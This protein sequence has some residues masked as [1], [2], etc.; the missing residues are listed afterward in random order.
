MIYP[1]GDR[2]LI[3]KAQAVRD[4]GRVARGDIERVV[5]DGNRVVIGIDEVGRGCLAGPVYAAA[6]A[7][8]YKKLSARTDAEKKLIR[9]SKT[10]SPSQRGRI[11]P[12]IREISRSFAVADASVC[13]IDSRG[14]LQATFLAMHRA[15]QGLQVVPEFLLIDGHMPLPD[16]AIPQ[17]PV[18]KGDGL[19][20]AIAAASI[21]AKEARDAYMRDISLSHP[22][23]AFGEHAGYGTKQHLDAIYKVGPCALHRRSFAPVRDILA[24]RGI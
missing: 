14:I 9:D 4:S 7:L 15:I 10:L 12:V 3:G 19:C 23:Y 20:F 16:S 13:E 22:E 8:D 17:L 2:D 1:V 5:A 6:V 21:M 11:L 18:I 24:G